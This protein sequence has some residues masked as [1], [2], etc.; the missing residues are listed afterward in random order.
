MNRSLNQD[1]KTRSPAANKNNGS[2]FFT[3]LIVGI[4]L[5][6][7]MTVALILYIKGDNSPF[8]DMKKS[9][10]TEV[11][12][13]QKNISEE[14]VKP[15]TAE[16]DALEDP[17]KFDFYTI[18]PS[19]ESKVTEQE[20]QDNPTIKKDVYFLQVG[21][22]NKEDD[23]NNL[24]AK[25]ALQGFQGIVQTANIPNKGTWH[26]VRVGPLN[27]LQQIND[28]RHDLESNGFKADLIKVHEEAKV[29]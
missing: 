21:A 24:K 5:G 7:A 9:N 8:A 12:V 26:R 28:T 23:A 4:L 29:Q 22:F 11:P 14:E 20:V 27:D 17:N 1:Y 13:V 19:T 25:L 3:G 18:L 2:T 10:E 15:N 16:A 6:V